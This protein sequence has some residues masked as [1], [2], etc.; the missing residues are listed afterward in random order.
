M[1]NIKSSKKRALTNEKRRSKNVTRRSELK[2]ATRKFAEA[3]E[4]K[5]V[6][7]AKEILRDVNAKMARAKGKNVVKANTAG[8]KMSRLSKRLNKAQKAA[9]K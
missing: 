7:A 6:A 9:T 1:A 5:D 8:R 2:T 3:L 4:N